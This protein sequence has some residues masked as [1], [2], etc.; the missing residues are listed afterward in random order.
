MK[1][2]KEFMIKGLDPELRKK[3]KAACAWHGKTMKSSIMEYMQT[4]V[5]IYNFKMSHENML[6]PKSSKEVKEK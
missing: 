6:K 1:V 5:S 4:I 3:F 2:A